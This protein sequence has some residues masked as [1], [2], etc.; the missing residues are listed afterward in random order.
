[1]LNWIHKLIKKDEQSTAPFI[2]IRRH[3]IVTDGDGVT[4]LVAFHGCN[5]H[6]K[7]C[8]NSQCL[9]KDGIWKRFTLSS[10]YTEVKKDNLYFNE[11]EG[12]ICFGGGEPLKYVDFIKD[13]KALCPETWKIL[14]ETSL[15]VPQDNLI[16]VAGVVDAYI[17]DIKDM[18]PGIYHAYTGQD[19]AIVRDNLKWLAENN[20]AN[21]VTI[22]TPLIPNYN[23]QSDIDSSI[24][25][26]TAMGYSRFESLTYTTEKV[27]NKDYHVI[28]EIVGKATCRYLKNIR[29]DV[30]Q[31]YGIEYSPK[32]CTHKGPC[33]GT[34]PVCDRELKYIDK[35][36]Y[37]QN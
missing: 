34:C 32:E 3:R 37:N 14:I 27:T 17:I 22:R 6:C 10:L 2:G 31:R 28:G 18:N 16:S 33:A 1:M 15:N 36:V 12:G 35:H 25:E 24:A 23:S 19:N 7:Y 30:A 20:H 21:K 9:A 13:F 5:L 8:L 4:T 29:L 11:T 26:L